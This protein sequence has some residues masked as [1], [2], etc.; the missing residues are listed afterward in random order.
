MFILKINENNK[1]SENDV[2]TPPKKPS[3]VLFGLI[4]T[5]LVLP[6]DFPNMY[7]K[8]SKVITININKLKLR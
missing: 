4:F 5:N 2:N 1:L 7:E 6:K 8:I 3:Y